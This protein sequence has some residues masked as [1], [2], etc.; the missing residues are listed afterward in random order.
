MKKESGKKHICID[1]RHLANYTDG[2]ARYVFDI[3]LA[4]A[5]EA[6]NLEICITALVYRDAP[7]HLAL[8]EAGIQIIETGIKAGA[9]SQHWKIPALLRTINPDVYYYPFID[10]PLFCTTRRRY[11]AV[12]DLNHYFFS[13]YA[14]TER[15]YAILY[16]KLMLQIASLRYH[17]IVTISRYVEQQ[18]KK[19]LIGAK[20]T[21]AIY[22]GLSVMH[23]S[24]EDDTPLPTKYLLYVGNNRPHK[25]IPY[26]L[27]CF[28][29]L[30]DSDHTYH[31]V[32]AGNQMDRFETVQHWLESNAALKHKVWVIQKP[33][34]KQINRLYKHAEAVVNL[35][36]SEGFGF[37]ILEAWYFQKPIVVLQASCFPEIAGE[38]ALY[39]RP[40]N[41]KSFAL[42]VTSLGDSAAIQKLIQLGS[43]RLKAFS[44]ADSARRHLIFLSS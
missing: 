17:G 14:A 9:L 12:H 26:L 22:H 4:M 6:S 40:N 2:L 30:V 33:T 23:F 34:Q 36:V 43:E 15:W 35:S 42:A 41:P 25:N 38:A 29:Q 10:P 13:K 20:R 1:C 19:H 32:L 31:L 44:W 16:A 18:V 27:E 39:T 28:K 37:P 3:T 21:I 24:G 11:F 5:G 8:K 7:L